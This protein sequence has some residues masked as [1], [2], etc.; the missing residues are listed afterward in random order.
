MQIIEKLDLPSKLEGI[1]HRLETYNHSDLKKISE[2]KDPYHLY[3]EV[4]TDEHKDKY[5]TTY[6]TSHSNMSPLAFKIANSVIPEEEELKIST[7]YERFIT[8]FRA[9][10]GD[11]FYIINYAVYKQVMLFNKKDLLFVK[12][13]RLT[14]DGGVVEITVSID[15]PDFH[16][17]KG[18]DRM[19][20]I[21]NIVYYK[22]TADNGTDIISLNSIYPRVGASFTILKP[23]FSRN[24]RSYQKLLAEYLHTVP[25]DE[26]KLEAEFVN[27]KKP[28]DFG[29]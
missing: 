1:I 20:I 29:L 10:I 8:I 6:M 9:K 19:K 26:R 12:A 23:L 28:A 21:E 7:S 14:P 25:N 13:F 22:R 15:H 11:V 4:K 18:T 3:F 2:D 24:Y 17:K 16:E 5:H 27:F